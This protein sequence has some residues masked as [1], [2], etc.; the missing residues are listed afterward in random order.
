[1]DAPAP[2]RPCPPAAPSVPRSS[3]NSRERTKRDAAPP[4]PAKNLLRA[5]RSGLEI[6]PRQAQYWNRSERKAHYSN[7][8]VKSTCRCVI[9]LSNA[10]N[11]C[12]QQLHLSS[13]QHVTQHLTPSLARL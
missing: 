13:D 11:S 4:A 12:K 5:S 7:C 9:S 2:C 6:Y 3:A 1:M 10:T 8:G